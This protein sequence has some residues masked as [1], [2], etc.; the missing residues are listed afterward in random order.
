LVDKCASCAN[1]RDIQAVPSIDKQLGNGFRL[2]AI[3]AICR[4]RGRIGGADQGAQFSGPNF[5]ALIGS[6]PISVNA[7]SRFAP[8]S[9]SDL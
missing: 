1:T 8:N 4:M 3:A 6:V 5:A 9:A 7:R 2:Q